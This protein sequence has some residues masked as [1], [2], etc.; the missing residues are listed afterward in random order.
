MNL[1]QSLVAFGI[2]LLTSNGWGWAANHTITANP[3]LTFSPS[4]LTINAGDTVTFTNAGGFHNAVIDTGS[5]T[6]R[7]ASGCDGDRVCPERESAQC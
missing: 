5:G 4:S 3:N 6:L 1:L 2:L 7:C